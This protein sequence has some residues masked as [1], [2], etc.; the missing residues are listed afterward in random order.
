MSNIDFNSIKQQLLMRAESILMDICPGGKRNG[1]EYRAGSIEGGAGDS[2][3][4]N[5]QTGKWADFAVQGHQ[6]NGIVD[7]YIIINNCEFKDAIN[8]LQETYLSKGQEKIKPAQAKPKKEKIEPI[9]PPLNIDEPS[10]DHYQLGKPSM[11]HAY[12]D[13]NDELLYY[14]LRYETEKD[15]VPDKEHRPLAY[16]SDNKWHWKAWPNNRPLYGLELLNKNPNLQVLIVEGE[17]AADAARRFIKGCNI[18]TWQGG[19]KAILKT[20]WSPLKDKQILLWPDADGPGFAA[21]KQIENLLLDHV[22]KL[23]FIETDRTNGWDAA[24]AEQE[25]MTH[26]S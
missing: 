23:K 22:T 10:F 17:K 24:D 19:A 7:L 16:F 26:G 6:G 2:F 8:Y 9:K 18:I 13:Q 5:L 15:G 12:K 3:G 25:G 1:N 11:V 21:M 20:D 14:V 4:F